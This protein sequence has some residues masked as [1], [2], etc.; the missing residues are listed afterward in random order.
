MLNTLQ[1][2]IDC[3]L[4]K[5]FFFQF[6]HLSKLEQNWILPRSIGNYTAKTCDIFNNC[7]VGFPA[8]WNRFCGQ[9]SSF[10][11]MKFC[12]ITHQLST[13]IRWRKLDWKLIIVLGNHL[14]MSNM[15]Q[16]NASST[17][18]RHFNLLDKQVPLF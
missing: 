12:T 18:Q 8:G 17:M 16:C 10:L 1:F 15:D 11:S 13:T 14:S 9:Y 4:K 7:F 6:S 5:D 2:F 3:W